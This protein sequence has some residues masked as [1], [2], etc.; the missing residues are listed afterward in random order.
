MNL[1]MKQEKTHR[2][3]EEACGCQKGNGAGMEWKFGVSRC[4]QLYIEWINN[5]VLP[6]ST[7]HYIQYPAT[8][9]NGKEYEEI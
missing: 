9:H 3:R 7:G 6:Y 8:N 5:K 1:S 4:K 2:H